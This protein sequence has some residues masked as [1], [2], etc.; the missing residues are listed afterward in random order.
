MEQTAAA[1]RRRGNWLVLGRTV[2]ACEVCCCYRAETPARGAGRRPPGRR[3]HRYA[4][5]LIN[6]CPRTATPSTFFFCCCWWR[7]RNPVGIFFAGGGFTAAVRE[8]IERERKLQNEHH[9]Y[10]GQQNNNTAENAQID[11]ING[12]EGTTNAWSDRAPPGWQG[13]GALA[14]LSAG[15]LI[16]RTDYRLMRVRA[17][18]WALRLSSAR[19][20]RQMFSSSVALS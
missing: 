10:H 9:Q 8:P 20:R 2:R 14:A 1:A 4:H 7:Q 18:P 17:L 5:I 12:N 3:E 13:T 15:W 11:E 6:G 16:W 19:N